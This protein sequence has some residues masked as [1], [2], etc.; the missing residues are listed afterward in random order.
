VTWEPE[1]HT[2][3][4]AGTLLSAALTHID[5]IRPATAQE[6]IQMMF[7]AGIEQC[8][9]SRSLLGKDLNGVLW[10][11]RVLVDESVL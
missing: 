3:R 11:A 4:S 7:R 5:L 6:P 9:V 8:I 1:P 2:P 10:L